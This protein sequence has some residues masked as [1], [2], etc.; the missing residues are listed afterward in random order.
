MSYSET[1]GEI[2]RNMP[3]VL[4]ELATILDVD[5]TPL[6]ISRP[7]DESM[8]TWSRSPK[9]VGTPSECVTAGEVIYP[10]RPSASI[11][12]PDG[13]V[14]DSDGIAY[15]VEDRLAMTANSIVLIGSDLDSGGKVALKFS[16]DRQ[17]IE[18]EYENIVS[19]NGHP[20]AL[21]LAGSGIIE[22][23]KDSSPALVTRF[24]EGTN[25]SNF[26]PKG[27]K[28]ANLAH[29]AEVIDPVID[30]L[31]V[32]EA[33]HKQ[34]KVYRDYNPRQ[35]IATPANH[36]VLTDLQ[37][38]A[39]EGQHMN[40]VVGTV[41]YMPPEALRN[42]EVRHE[43]DLFSIGLSI[44]KLIVGES[45]DVRTIITQKLSDD[46]KEMRLRELA[47]GRLPVDLEKVHEV[48]PAPLAEVIDISTERDPDDRV[49]EVADF[50]RALMQTRDQLI[51][52]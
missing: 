45:G 37:T 4:P 33:L 43:S 16:S 7:N 42:E 44:G 51:A 24:V 20:N 15:R 47:M 40:G 3:P 2:D 14:Y 28:Q 21:Q 22:G 46:Q 26:V 31:T 9:V 17:K 5:G 11:K 12:V 35:V 48:A 34:G 32:I 30:S 41:E 36:G 1:I 29:F 23:D 6:E 52:A 19:L 13:Y 25:L 27:S 50:K 18:E 39:Q 10:G 8:Q 49:I 38:V